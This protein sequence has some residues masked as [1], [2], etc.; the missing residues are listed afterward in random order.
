MAK[1]WELF[2]FVAHMEPKKNWAYFFLA[3][4]LIFYYI[5]HPYKRPNFGRAGACFIFIV[6]RSCRR[7]RKYSWAFQIG[8]KKVEFFFQDLYGPL[9]YRIYSNKPNLKND[10]SRMSLIHDCDTLMCQILLTLRLG[11]IPLFRVS[12][13]GKWLARCPKFCHPWT[14]PQT[15]SCQSC[16]RHHGHETIPVGI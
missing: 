5:N 14:R 11:S 7:F 2:G 3:K 9:Y 13:L 12:R 1:F 15:S 8:A 10:F 4:K 16:R 6:E